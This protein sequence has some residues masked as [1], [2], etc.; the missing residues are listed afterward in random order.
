MRKFW[1]EDVGGGGGG[2]VCGWGREG[3]TTRRKAGGGG[4]G[5]SGGD[6]ALL[7]LF[8]KKLTLFFAIKNSCVF[9]K[10]RSRLTTLI[11]NISLLFLFLK[12]SFEMFVSVTL[13]LPET[14]FNPEP[15]LCPPPPSALWEVWCSYSWVWMFFYFVRDL[16][17]SFFPC[18]RRVE[19]LVLRDEREQ[20]TAPYVLFSCFFFFLVWIFS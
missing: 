2:G 12:S 18:R 7:T 15:T 6:A 19:S 1:E 13:E 8:V 5:G 10:S 9:W 17:S 16:N 20:P 4:R 11:F 14:H 3:G